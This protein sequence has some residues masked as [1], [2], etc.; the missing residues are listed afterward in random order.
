MPEVHRRVAALD[1][2]V[3]YHP[4]L[5]NAILPQVEGV[6]GAMRELKAY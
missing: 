4:S 5:E 6:L 1:T 3:G 2:F